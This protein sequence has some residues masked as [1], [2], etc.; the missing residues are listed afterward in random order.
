MAPSWTPSPTITIPVL[1][2]DWGFRVI[3]YHTVGSAW[4]NQKMA[5]PLMRARRARVIKMGYTVRYFATMNEQ[6][7]QIAGTTALQNTFSSKPLAIRWR[8]NEDQWIG[9]AGEAEYANFKDMINPTA[10]AF[11]LVNE[12]MTMSEPLTQEAGL[13]DKF[14]YFEHAPLNGFSTTRTC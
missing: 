1:A 10:K 13:L 3:P 12:G 4:Q 8:M 11:T 2:Y 9:I 6:A 14:F 5:F 7:T